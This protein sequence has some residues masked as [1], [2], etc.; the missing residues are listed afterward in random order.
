MAPISDLHDVQFPKSNNLLLHDLG[1]HPDKARFFALFKPD[2]VF[3]LCVVFH[4]GNVIFILLGIATYLPSLAL[5][6]LAFH[7]RG[8]VSAGDYIYHADPAQTHG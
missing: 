1:N 6:R 7:S 5:A 8:F 2:T 3:V 4:C